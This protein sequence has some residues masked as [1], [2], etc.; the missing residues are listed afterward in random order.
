MSSFEHKCSLD[1]LSRTL[2]QCVL[3]MFCV[4]A[5]HNAYIYNQEKGGQNSV[6]MRRSYINCCCQI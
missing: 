1:Y 2:V 6:G 3:L 4:N 5:V